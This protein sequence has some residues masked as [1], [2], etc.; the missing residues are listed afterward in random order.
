[1]KFYIYAHPVV[2]QGVCIGEHN[3]SKQT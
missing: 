2:V 3:W 1:M